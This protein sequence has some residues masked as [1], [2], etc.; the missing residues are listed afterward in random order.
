MQHLQWCSI[1][2]FHTFY[3]FHPFSFPCINTKR[4][5][6]KD[7]EQ[8]LG[9]FSAWRRA[10]SLTSERGGLK[11]W[12]SKSLQIRL[13]TW[14]GKKTWPKRLKQPKQ[15]F[16]WEKQSR[17]EILSI[18][19]KI[20]IEKKND[21]Y[22]F[23]V[24]VCS[25]VLDGS[26]R[27]GRNQFVATPILSHLSKAKQKSRNRMES[28]RVATHDSHLWCPG[29]A[30]KDLI[31]MDPFA[32]A[33]ITNEDTFIMAVPVEGPRCQGPNDIFPRQNPFFHSR[34]FSKRW[35]K[36]IQGRSTSRWHTSQTY[37]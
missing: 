8:L 9:I 7:T 30:P 31:N 12:S 4:C 2:A 14:R 35:I 36:T 26:F 11:S 25:W 17:H 22:M 27:P 1:T 6:R 20:T 23:L 21:V 28:L 32:T 29:I 19:S 33:A 16:S 3:K 34:P 10:F 24:S 13:L 15:E 37:F 5:P 18:E